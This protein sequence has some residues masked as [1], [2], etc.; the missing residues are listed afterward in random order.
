MNHLLKIKQ[1][2]LRSFYFEVEEK[3]N[4]QMNLTEHSVPHRVI[5][6]LRP[7]REQWPPLFGKIKKFPKGHRLGLGGLN[8]IS[9]NRH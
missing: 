3:A 4:I 5:T 2:L 1:K 8:R 6:V 7:L 9:V